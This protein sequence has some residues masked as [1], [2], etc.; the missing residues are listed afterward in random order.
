[1]ARTNVTQCICHKKTFI[2]I[3]E[4]AKR[5]NVSS[6]EE[7]QEVNFCSNSCGLCEPYVELVLETGQTEFVPG[8]P[9]RKKR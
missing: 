3:R 4:H 6:V 9:F 1:M 8:E 2:E 5:N 7:L